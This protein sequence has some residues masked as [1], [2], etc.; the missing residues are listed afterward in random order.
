VG[1][2]NLAKE[3][4]SKVNELDQKINKWLLDTKARMPVLK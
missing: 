3:N 1:F 4:I 2:P